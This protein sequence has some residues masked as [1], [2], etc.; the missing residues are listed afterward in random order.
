[1]KKPFE[2]LFCNDSLLAVD[3]PTGLLSVPDRFHEEKK[4]LSGLVMEQYKTARPLH[5]LDFETSGIILFCLDPDAFGW[6]SD[7]FENRSVTKTYLAICEGRC[8]NTEGVIDA[9]LFTQTTGKVIITKRGKSSQTNWKLL[10]GFQHHSLIEANP[11]TGRTHQIRVHLTSIGLPI[12]GD[13]V[14]GSGRPLNLSALK[15]KN[16]YRLSKDAEEER[17][18][19]S[20]VALHAASIR[21]KDFAGGGEIA[22]ESPLPKDLRVG[23]EKLRQYTSLAK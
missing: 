16:K 8:M 19:I 21:I 11:L 23:L 18:L 12:V 3:K 17:P 22:V 15:G 9:P 6:Y 1:M 5:R 2:I 4:S 20:R 7:Q 10:E 13:T 14:Y